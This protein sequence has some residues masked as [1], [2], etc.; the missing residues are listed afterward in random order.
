[1][2]LISNIKVIIIGFLVDAENNII[3]NPLEHSNCVENGEM[4]YRIW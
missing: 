2:Q 3:Y 4:E 1:M